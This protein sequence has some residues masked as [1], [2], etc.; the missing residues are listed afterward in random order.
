VTD[1]HLEARV[2]K[3]GFVRVAGADY[4]VLPGLAGRRVQLQLSP[5]EV[6]ARL[7]GTEASATCAASSPRMSWLA[8]ATPGALRLEREA[9]RRLKGNDV[10]VPAVDLARYDAVVRIS[11]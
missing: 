1:R 3:D 7:D 2:S 11:P 8:L 4:S 6:V 10:A 5:T 9:R